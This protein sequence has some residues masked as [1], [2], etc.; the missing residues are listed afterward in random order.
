MQSLP[1]STRRW[2]ACAAA[3][4]V[5]GLGQSL[6]AQG[7]FAGRWSG[8]LNPGPAFVLEIGASGTTARLTIGAQVE[9][10]RFLGYSPEGLNAYYWREQ[11]HAVISV[12]SSGGTTRCAYLEAY[13]LRTTT[14]TFQASITT[15]LPAGGVPTPPAAPPFV[16]RWSGQLTPGPAFEI[17]IFASGAS[18]TFKDA[19]LGL[20][21][22]TFVGYEPTTPALYYWRAQDHAI[23]CLY[24]QGGGVGF[25]YL[26]QEVLRTGMLAHPGAANLLANGSF[27]A[28][29]P[30][31]FLVLNAGSNAIAPW[32]ITSGGIDITNGAPS[33]GPQ[34]GA[35]NIDLDGF[36]QAGTIAQNFNAQAG[37]SYLLSFYMSANI[38]DEPVKRIEVVVGNKTQIFSYDTAQG[39]L[40]A[41]CELPFQA[42]SN[43]ERIVVRSLS[44]SGSAFGACLDNFVIEDISGEAECAA[45][46]QAL[47]DALIALGQANASVTSLTQQLAASQAALSIANA[48]IVTMETSLIQSNARIVTLETQNATLQQQLTAALAR[49]AAL[50]SSSN[51]TTASLA[52]V[53]ADF[54]SE[55]S[56]PGFVIP[57]ATTADKV[58]NLANAV[59]GLN[60]GRKRDVYTPLK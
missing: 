18:G 53:E 34:N 31:N 44:H 15:E 9:P 33:I 37:K 8:S 50:Q 25:S 24:G 17:E 56:D 55:F 28:G 29:T 2:S 47:D 7:E 49:T 4:F 35:R 19:G 58:N 26:E 38:G 42:L 59:I 32:E 6:W 51:A 10:L 36:Y 39:E 57:G 46:Q 30:G 13:Y 22:L 21:A 48:R 54:R 60:H 41:R 43:S 23:V 14:L 20:E 3:L 27:E 52:R 5:L 12:F 11:D 40:W 16:G 45:L 1:S